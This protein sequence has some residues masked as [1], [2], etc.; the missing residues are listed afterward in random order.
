MAASG[1]V[2]LA[3]CPVAVLVGLLLSMRY[4]TMDSM[5]STGCPLSVSWSMYDSTSR[6]LLSSVECSR[7]RC[8]SLVMIVRRRVLVRV[9]DG[10]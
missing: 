8:R 3:V 1:V 6:Q 10:E 7:M 5:R 2:M 9:R 4:D